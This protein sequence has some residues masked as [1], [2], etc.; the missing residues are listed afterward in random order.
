MTTVLCNSGRFYA[1]ISK[2]NAGKVFV[3]NETKQIAFS[4]FISKLAARRDERNLNS[5]KNIS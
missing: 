2:E 5:T 3:L 1:D 4:K